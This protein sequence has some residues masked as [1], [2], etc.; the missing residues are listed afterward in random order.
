MTQ[1][2]PDIEL[3]LAVARKRQEQAN[4]RRKARAKRKA[5]NKL[6]KKERR[7]NRQ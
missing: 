3:M 4:K 5:H 1:V 7:K 6:V 2:T